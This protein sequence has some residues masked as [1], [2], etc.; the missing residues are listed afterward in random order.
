MCKLTK[1]VPE[2]IPDGF[3]TIV[4]D[5]DSTLYTK[6]HPLANLYIEVYSDSTYDI[7]MEDTSLPGYVFEAQG[8][9][10]TNPKDL[11]ILLDDCLEIFNDYINLR[12]RFNNLL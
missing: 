4:R 9:R 11:P 3:S 2:P 7:F 10:M 6:H 8:A 12:N 5:R 1:V